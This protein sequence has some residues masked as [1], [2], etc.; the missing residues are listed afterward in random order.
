MKAEYDLSAMKRKGHPLRQKVLQGKIKLIN[1]LDI[2]DMELKL[3]KLAPG[4]RESIRE[5]IES[6]RDTEKNTF[7]EV[8]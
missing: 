4:E 8:L 2:P 1:P 7:L 6:L 5:L 3:S